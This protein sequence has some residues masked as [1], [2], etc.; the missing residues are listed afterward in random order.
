MLGR[1]RISGDGLGVQLGRVR[2]EPGTGLQDVAD[3][4]AEKQ[5]DRR[6]DLEIQQRF[7][8]DAAN[9]LHAAHGGDAGH[10]R[11]EHDQGDHHL[12]QLDE[13]I[14]ERLHRDRK[15][16]DRNCRQDDSQ[17]NAHQHLCVKGTIKTEFSAL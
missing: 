4:H 13:A 9:L 14:A 5:G 12:D 6:H 2:V 1:A 3:R 16:W 7:A 10:D 17:H 15:G 11:A 8:A